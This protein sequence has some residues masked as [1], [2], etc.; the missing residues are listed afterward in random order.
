MT[1][2]VLARKWRPQVFQDVIGQEH[3]AQT[4]MNA[5]KTGRLAHAYLFSGP[6][7]VGK[8]SV[9]RIFAKAINC[10]QGEPGVPCNQCRSCIEITNGSSIDVQEIDGAS[11]RGIDE[12][13]ELRESI[14]YMPSSSKY[15]IY[16]IDEVHMLTLPAFNALLKTLEEPPVHVKFIFATTESHKVPVT[17]LSR[18]QRYDFKR[19]PAADIVAHLKK[20]AENEGIDIAISG[21]GIIAR[22]AEGSMRDAQS[23][24]DQVISFSGQSVR[25]KDIADILGII[26]RDVIFESSAAIL[27]RAPERCLEIVERI[28]NYGYDIKEFYR[29]LMQQFRNL[30]IRLIAPHNDLID[31]SDSDKDEIKRQSELASKEK[32]HLLLNFLINREEDLR[33]TSHPRLVLETT[34]VKLCTLG[35]VL[36]FEELLKRVAALEEK[37]TGAAASSAESAGQAVPERLSDPGA[38]W[39]SDTGGS[40]PVNAPD[41]VQEKNDLSSGGDP[42]GGWN[43]FLAFLA[44]KS[45]PAHSILKDWRVLT[46]TPDVL[47]IEGQSESFSSRYFDDSE[48]YDQLT[49]HCQEFFGRELKVTIRGRGRP[50]SF[51]HSKKK[52]ATKVVKAQ[53]PQNTPIPRAA[54][55]VLSLFDGHIVKNDVRSDKMDNR[56]GTIDEGN[57]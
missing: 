15:R 12:I 43:D 42:P 10:E 17:I 56:G 44:T 2:Q 55:E 3:V 35:D 8:T 11:N 38:E 16:V 29:A 14:R 26:D 4:L 36:S 20:I 19:I 21:L 45:K 52:P 51:G 13:R 25:D 31:V 49:A 53:D 18:C 50:S 40:L 7:G 22:E 54:Q 9:A 34:L 33:F 46:L 5:I 32:L 48:R 30:L 1:Y 28:Y 57:A 41:A 37:L 47:E 6:R 24:M 23:L 39:R 27:E